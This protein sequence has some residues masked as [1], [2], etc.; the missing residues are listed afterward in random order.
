VEINLTKKA[1]VFLDAAQAYNPDADKPEQ[2]L[3]DWFTAEGFDALTE[4]IEKVKQFVTVAKTIPHKAN[5]LLATHG[6]TFDEANAVINGYLQPAVTLDAA[7]NGGALAEQQRKANEDLF[8]EIPD[9]FKQYN[10]WLTFESAEKKAPIISGTFAHAKSND[11]STWVSYTT[12]LQNI[13][14]GKG[15]RNVGFCPDSERTGYLT[16]ID[17]DNS[18]NVQTG[19]I[20]PWAL[21]ILA[22]LGA[23]YTEVTVSGSGLRAWV[24]I[25]RDLHTSFDLGESAKAN[26][27]KKAAQIEVF[28]DK[29]YA[30]LSRA[31]LAE[32][33]KSVRELTEADANAFFQLLAELQREFPATSANGT[34]GIDA[35]PNGEK[36]LRG[37]HDGELHRI[38]GK[39]RSIGMEQQAIYNALVEICEK[40]CEGYGSDYLLMC[41]KHARNIVKKPVGDGSLEL[42]MKPDSADDDEE[43][44]DDGQEEKFPECPIFT[45]ALTDLARALFPSLPLEFKQW[46]LI[47]RW[48][49]MRSGID[50]FGLEQHLQPRFY[51]IFVCHPNRG[52]TACL[53]ETRNTMD[54]V[55]KAVRNSCANTGKPVACASVENLPSVDSGQFLAETFCTNTVDLNCADSNVK[56]MVDTD[57]MSDVFEKGRI[58]NGNKSTLFIELLKLYS[59]NR[60]GSG[61]KKDGKKIVTNAHLAVLGGTTV[62][63]YPMLWTGTG[64]GADGLVSRFIPITT[65]NAPLPPAVLPTDLVAAKK[66]YERLCVLAQLPPQNVALTPEAAVMLDKWWA[67]ADRTKESATRVL[68]IIKQLLIVLAVVNDSLAVEPDLMKQAIAFGEYVIAIRERLN[69]ADSWS[70]IQA[71]ENAII[72][73]ARKNASRKEPKTRNECRRGVH[74]NRKPGGLAAFNFAWDSTVK[75]GVMKLRLHEGKGQWFSL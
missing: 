44:F 1:Q 67:S 60:T 34:N 19:Q 70:N 62:K 20:A 57:E 47:A 18:V 58:L 54:A 75:A 49:L 14:A 28:N 17:I 9:I 23:T 64:G 12:L 6:F 73:W 8:P 39:L 53:N 56:I 30:T 32:S 16:A 5:A 69:P 26:Q 61:T 63:K 46:G 31:V 7:P 37:K 55:A 48:G 21:R 22:F 10:N 29:K 52:K 38:A 43:T 35:S 66:A 3:K 11:S 36:I 13:R 42:D 50:T 4:D 51:S 41:E 40:R 2:E 68:D 24:V 71:M 72:E 59:G 15:Y 27:T 33:V 65:N 25:K 45:G 74:P